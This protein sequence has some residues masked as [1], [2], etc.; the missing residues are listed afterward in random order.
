V[1]NMTTGASLEPIGP[2]GRT[3]RRAGGRGGPAMPGTRAPKQIPGLGRLEAI[4]DV[5][6][7]AI[8]VKD[9]DHRIVLVNSSACALFGHSREVI[10]SSYDT[11][12][13]PA[14]EVAVF[15]EADDK[16]FAAGED[17]RE[18]QLTDAHGEVRT[19][20]TRKQ[21]TR[22]DGADYLVGIVS[23]VS[24][25][26]QAEAKNHYLAFHDTLT[27]LPNRALLNERID[28]ALVQT[29]RGRGR[30]ALLYVD[31][32]HFKDVN[33]SH[34]HQVG[35]ELVRMFASR[36]AG[37]VRASDT[38]A[39]LGGDEFAVLLV[40]Q[41]DGRCVDEL[42]QQIL[43]EAATPFA[44]AGLRV[45]TGA[46]IGVAIAPDG[47]TDQI[48]LQRRADVALYQAKSEGR[49]C[50]R[51]Y[52]DA[53]NEQMQ[54]VR[55]L[56]SEMREALAGGE[57]FEV[58]YQPIANVET[59]QAEGYEALA[60]WHHPERGMIMPTEFIP[61]AETSGLI[62]ELGEWV[63][64]RAC[65]DAAKWNPPLRL[66]VNI[67]PIQFTRG[68]P[69]EMVRR[70]LAASG[71][72]AERLELEITEGVLIQD[73]AAA[74]AM[75]SRLRALGVKI[76]LDD[77]GTGYSSLS[78]F[79]QFPFDKVKIDRSFVNDMLDSSHARSIVETIISLGLGLDLQVVAEGVETPQ[80]L[81]LLR[82][83]GCSQ[84][85]GFLVGRPMPL[86]HFGEPV[87][88]LPRRRV[89]RVALAA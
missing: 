75:L 56:E 68:D 76:V 1:T 5:V 26:R 29:R 74:L 34:G 64:A 37:L 2:P 80:Q 33:D 78:Y 60:R 36:L 65:A 63:L 59:G 49:G 44:I 38:V 41:G 57:G 15:H 40:D 71:L 22:I 16:V 43:E 89:L 54:A 39:R 13:Y 79:K 17:E 28:R 45:V 24:A 82:H 52:S 48:E 53:I 30:C 12:L 77:F 35:D 3:S 18:E 21:R 9:R 7:S 69:V 27:E 87:A 66:S 67:S 4:I 58:Y 10:L 51:S 20:I 84:A 83:L 46:S 32:D 55:W 72:A 61:V 6:P 73:P 42:C 85:Q 81:R 70:A 14:E 31:L 11:D 23:D 25:Y 47:L 62:V 50:C 19:L 88:V 8:F 86:G